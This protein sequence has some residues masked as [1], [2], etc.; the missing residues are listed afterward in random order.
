MSLDGTIEVI[1]PAHLTE[2]S[3]AHGSEKVETSITLTGSNIGGPH[4]FCEFTFP[5]APGAKFGCSMTTSTYK[6]SAVTSTS[7]VCKV[8]AWP[9]PLT[10]YDGHGGFHPV[11]GAV[12]S[13]EVHVQLTNDA[14]VTS[15]ELLVFR[16]DDVSEVLV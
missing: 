2:V 4:V 5:N 12:C 16:Y 3:P 13:R 10:Q 14:R 6:A 7:A 9:G 15:Q 8:P 1:E 11:E